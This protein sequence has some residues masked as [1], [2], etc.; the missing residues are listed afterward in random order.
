MEMKD[1]TSYLKYGTGL[2]I[3]IH[4]LI[5][6][7][8][9]YYLNIWTDEA[10]TLYATQNGFWVAFQTAVIEQ[11]QAPFYFWLLS[12]WRL[13]NESIFFARLF[14][15]LSS[16]AAIW[17]FAKLAG[18]LM[19]PKAALLA[20]AFFALHPFL[21]W[22]SVE[23]RVYSLVILLSLGLI[24]TFLD[25]FWDNAEN[26]IAPI[27]RFAILSVIA[28]YTNYYLG[29][30]LV[31]FLIPLIIYRRWRAVANYLATMVVV[32]LAFLPMILFVRSEM[33]A[34]SSVFVEDRS[35]ISGLRILWNHVLTYLLPTEIFST[36][37]TSAAAVAR[38][39]LVRLL[40]V[41][42]TGFT[43]A[44]WR[45]VSGHTIVLGT[46]VATILA[47]LLVAYFTVGSWL[48]A[49]RHASLLF[50]PLL[51]FFASLLN[52]LFREDEKNRKIF[53]FAAPAFAAIVIACFA[54]TLVNLYPQLAKRGDW[55]R[56][57]Q[58]IEQNEKPDQP[59]VI[60]H[61]YDAL[62]LPY[63]YS[64]VNRILPD[65]RYFE[66]DFGTP[67]PEFV[68]R[69]TAFTLSKIPID[70]PE[71]W[72]LMNDECN[73]PGICESFDEY[74]AANYTV[75]TEQSFYGQK[76]YLLKKRAS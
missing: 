73:T 11:K 72:L 69:R 21:F 67:T 30:M 28:L 41:V 3:F 38:L 50:P 57:G 55:A 26:R 36:Y 16:V 74:I 17:L 61:T 75:V 27:V 19:R 54:Y 49:I 33:N 37:V 6:I 5:A 62:S 46:T 65:E 12:F 35:I 7:P 10:S 52:D 15:I 43:L 51:L 70:A 59:I 42:L 53:H 24:Y 14:S 9:S 2:L 8:L 32:G 76:A 13:V 22:A 23:I 31:G 68:A 4:L 63:H 39:W 47:F 1:R 40:L 29:P 34:R 56:V 44:R 71:I 25:A 45:R 66:F 20:T 60:F 58:F 64:G 18:R 48:V